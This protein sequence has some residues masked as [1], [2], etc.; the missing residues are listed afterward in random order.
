[1]LMYKVRMCG[2]VQFSR[3]NFRHCLIVTLIAT[4]PHRRAQVADRT[5]KKAPDRPSLQKEIQAIDKKWSTLI[6]KALPGSGTTSWRCL[7]TST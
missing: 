4:T 2:F 7:S 6:R 1:M 5:S 3:C